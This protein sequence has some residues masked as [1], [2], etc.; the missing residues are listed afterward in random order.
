MFLTVVNDAPGERPKR[1]MVVFDCRPCEIA[2]SSLP[3]E[4]KRMTPFVDA[5]ANVITRLDE[6]GE[7]PQVLP[8]VTHPEV[9]GL[10]VDGHPPWVAVPKRP[11]FASGALQF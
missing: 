7:F 4:I 6:V 9:A 3:V 5:P 8:V 11:D 10:R 2:G 1:S